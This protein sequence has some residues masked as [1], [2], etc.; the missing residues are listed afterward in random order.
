MIQC[1]NIK[2]LEIHYLPA[3]CLLGV[4]SIQ[5]ARDDFVFNLLSLWGGFGRRGNLKLE[6]IVRGVRICS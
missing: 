6:I 1:L 3:Y 4:N 5:E 2:T